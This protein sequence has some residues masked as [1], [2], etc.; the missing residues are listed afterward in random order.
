MA[1]VPKRKKLVLVGV[2]GL[3]ASLIGIF[4]LLIVARS[5]AMPPDPIPTISA[6][7]IT[8]LAYFTGKEWSENTFWLLRNGKVTQIVPEL[9]FHPEY[10]HTSWSP[11]GTRLAFVAS[12]LTAGKD[13][14]D[15]LQLR[16]LDIDSLHMLS[17]P[18][19]PESMSWSPDGTMIGYT[20]KNGDFP[21]VYIRDAHT[22]SVLYQ[23]LMPDAPFVGWLD[24]NRVLLL[25][26]K[27][28]FNGNSQVLRPLYVF[29][30]RRSSAIKLAEN[31]NRVVASPDGTH[32]A[33]SVSQKDAK[34][35]S[36]L[37]LND[38]GKIV[39]THAEGNIRS[40]SP[41]GTQIVYSDNDWNLFVSPADSVKPIS[42]LEQ[43]Q[44]KIGHLRNSPEDR[45][46]V[47]QVYG[48]SRDSKYLYIDLM[49][50]NPAARVSRFDK[51]IYEVGMRGE[52]WQAVVNLPTSVDKHF[53]WIPY[54]SR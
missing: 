14:S 54:I 33:V 3:V 7:A 10:L 39:T 35:T 51:A 16:I 18:D 5:I 4:T 28:T 42:L 29:D 32:L 1:T 48:W 37:I 11:N 49:V 19:L 25:E 26:N 52:N 38:A 30:L 20:V 40:W 12:E 2:V 44:E 17:L 34:T 27:M 8:H 23:D 31:V 46:S 24:S 21:R 50:R 6:N 9:S 15:S 41:D 36:I 53:I 22:G 13:V 47:Y 43:H 45:I